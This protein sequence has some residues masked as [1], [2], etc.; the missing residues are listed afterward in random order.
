MGEIYQQRALFYRRIGRSKDFEENF[1]NY[2]NL[3]AIG[4]K[5]T[6]ELVEN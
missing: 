1:T 6:S 2:T 4:A 5:H 3:R